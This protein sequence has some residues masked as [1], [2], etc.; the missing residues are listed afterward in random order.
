MPL[1]SLSLS[2]PSKT[3]HSAIKITPQRNLNQLTQNKE[4]PSSRRDV[5]PSPPIKASRASAVKTIQ[6]QKICLSFSSLH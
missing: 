5:T 4:P 3:T 2:L 1:T 6:Q